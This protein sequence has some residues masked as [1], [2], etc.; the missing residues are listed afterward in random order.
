MTEPTVVINVNRL[1]EHLVKG[2]ASL[3]PDTAAFVEGFQAAGWRVRL[4]DWHSLDLNTGQWSDL[5]DL[6]ERRMVEVTDIEKPADLAVVRSVGSVEAQFDDIGR[7][8]RVLKDQLGSCV[9][10]H[11]DA[12][13]YG[14]DKKYIIS[15]TQRG[16]PTIPT[17]SFEASVSL[18]T[19]L[20][21]TADWGAGAT[22]VKPVTGE[23]GNSCALLD[24]ISEASLRWKEDKVGGWLAQPF[25]A[26]VMDGER[27]FVFVGTRCIYGVRK[28]PQRSQFKVNSRWEPTYSLCQI[29]AHEMSLALNIHDAWHLPLHTWRL[30]LVGPCESPQIMEV[31]TVN[32]GFYIG[33][34]NL[35]NFQ[36][37][38]FTEITSH[39]R[40]LLRNGRE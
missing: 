36:S 26:E 2:L 22:V 31:E 34:V 10:N 11:P 3:A 40:N 19:L 7:Y 13:D 38:L 9:I 27:S 8:F 37:E 5:Y 28:T 20:Q 21:E 33:K 29:S 32:P 18:E 15:L 16:F 25:V 35:G 12:M 39:A 14:K 30:D 17:R 6:N 1:G 23:A 24:S 4:A